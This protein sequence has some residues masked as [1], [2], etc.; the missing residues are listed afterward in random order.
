MK[1]KI[2]AT[3]GPAS[4]KPETMEKMAEAGMSVCRINTKYGSKEEYLRIVE[5]SRKIK[6]LVMYDVKGDG[7]LEW[8]KDQ[9]F[10]YLAVAFSET[11][12]QLDKIRAFFAP[13]EI[14][15]IAKIES[16]KGFDNLEEVIK[17][18]DGVMVAR[19]DLGKNVGVEKVPIYQ[20][21]IIEHCNAHKKP[22]ITATEMLLSMVHSESPERAEA[23]DIANAVLDGSDY[24]M[25]S[26]ETTVG[27][28]PILVVK[29]M[30]K[31]IKETEKDEKL[32]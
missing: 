24:L 7:L 6:C 31:I 21:L 23:S 5:N 26:E 25:L 15:L 18:S 4:E 8:L 27:E 20:K 19:G 3:I 1:T 2:I 16:E 9:D 28:N 14:N 22:V 13:R 32:L 12:E 10:D 29:T 30:A 11:K 17:A